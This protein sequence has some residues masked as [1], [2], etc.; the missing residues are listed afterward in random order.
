[1]AA[2]LRI[3]ISACIAVITLLGSAAQA[4]TVTNRDDR[5]HKITIVE[6]EAKTDHVLKPQ[7]V[8]ADLCAKG[9]I[10]RLNDSDEEEYELE[11]NDAVSIEDGYLYYEDADPPGAAPAP[12]TKEPSK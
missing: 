8:L 6:G 11:A 7:A 3:T 1:M 2:T 10:L 12:G 4:V 9:C 5:E